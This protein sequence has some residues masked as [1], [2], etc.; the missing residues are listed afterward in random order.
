MSQ[1]NVQ[2]HIY[3][4]YTDAMHY[5]CPN[6]YVV[7]DC[8]ILI[9]IIGIMIIYYQMQCAI[10]SAFGFFLYY[11]NDWSKCSLFLVTHNLDIFFASSSIV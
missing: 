6:K 7:L 1:S 11:I 9:V 10:E 8:P 3:D 5:C 2:C 4:D